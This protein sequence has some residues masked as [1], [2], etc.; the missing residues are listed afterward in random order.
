MNKL[1]CP[2][3]S[4][5]KFGMFTLLRF[6]FLKLEVIEKYGLRVVKSVNETVSVEKKG[7]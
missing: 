6:W 5:L 3:I 7:V 2:I 4:L 1:Q